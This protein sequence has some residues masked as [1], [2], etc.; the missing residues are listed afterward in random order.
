[1]TALRRE[2]KNPGLERNGPWI[3]QVPYGV[4]PSA[5]ADASGYCRKDPQPR[6]Q[7]PMNPPSPI[8]SMVVGPRRRQRLLP[9]R[10]PASSTA[11]Y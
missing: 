10:A 7:R 1:M 4:W 6:A 3:R 11:A 8:R 5:R 9:K 2:L